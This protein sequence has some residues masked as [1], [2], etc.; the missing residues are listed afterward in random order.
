MRF[1]FVEREPFQARVV[2]IY[3]TASS[4]MNAGLPH[5]T[6]AF[7]ELTQCTS[8]DLLQRYT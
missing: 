6:T 7:V 1:A 8:H 5:A 3:E 4:V 2:R